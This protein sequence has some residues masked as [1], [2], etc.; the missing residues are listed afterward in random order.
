MKYVNTMTLRDDMFIVSVSVSAIR[1]GDLSFTKPSWF[2]NC[3]VS[4]CEKEKE[5]WPHTREEEG[6]REFGIGGKGYDIFVL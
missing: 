3:V 2:T 4:S 1:S 5:S 6:G